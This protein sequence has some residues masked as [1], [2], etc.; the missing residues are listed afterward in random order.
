MPTIGNHEYK[1]LTDGS[2][3]F[4]YWNFPNGSPTKTGRRRQLVQPQRGGRRWHII[5]L[6]SNVGMTLNP[7]TPQGTG[8]KQDLAADLAARPKS[9]APVHAG[10]LARRRG[11]RTSASASR[12]RRLLEPA[13][14]LR[15]RPHRQRPLPRLRALAA[16]EQLRPGDHQPRA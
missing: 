9:D 15:R 1:Q 12:R 8:S 13:L 14:P 10:L 6:N 2:G 3:Y 5:S 4:W 16:A 11:S 7:P